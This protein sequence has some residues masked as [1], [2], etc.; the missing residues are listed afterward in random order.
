[1]KI[2]ILIFSW[3]ITSLQLFSQPTFEKT[4]GTID[5]DMGNS[6]TVCDDGTY[7]ISGYVSN[8]YTGYEDMYVARI[9]IFG[10]TIWTY[11]DGIP[12]GY[13]NGYQVIQSY[14]GGFVIA[15]YTTVSDERAPCL[16]KLDLAGNK[17][18]SKEFSQYIPSGIAFSL[19]ES[20]D[21]GLVICGI[22]DYY[23]GKNVL[24][25]RKAHLLKTNNVGEYIWD[26]SFGSFGIHYATG[27]CLSSDNGLVICGEY[28]TEGEY[29]A[30]WLFKTNSMGILNWNN[31]YGGNSS[32]E[33]AWKVARTLDGGYIFVGTVFY[34]II[35]M[36]GDIYVVKTDE[37]GTEEW[38][39]TYG[40][41]SDE[42]GTCIEATTDGGYLICG[43]TDGFGS[44]SDD[45][46]MIKT[47]ADGDTLWT[48]TYGGQYEE[49]AYAVN[50]TS[51]GGFILCG[52]TNS[53]GL[54]GD[55]IYLIKTN[56]YG[57]LTDVS[58]L[59]DAEFHIKISPNPGNAI[60]NVSN[61]PEKCRL[62]LSTVNGSKIFEKMDVSKN[63]KI[64]LSNFPKGI[65]LLNTE[66][67]NRVQSFKIV[68]N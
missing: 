44:G 22:S 59:S 16:V 11:T 33:S 48:R 38:S 9:D 62:V 50:Q 63:F 10:D 52:F 3:L 26:H 28:D 15:G 40:G 45:I 37:N 36:N 8:L 42:R 17:L 1:M 56:M 61:L 6:V 54:G 24:W 51:D 46:W 27:I 30:A 68:K 4:Y 5:D 18:W 2:K 65:Y 35:A 19:L 20:A 58:E 23:N 25:Q 14:D 67:G 53:S 43:S 64:D 31:T 21:S 7:I 66:T 57:L 29:T 12:F 55:D 47:N 34:G 32:M 13:D 60:F 39:K 49:R 41:S